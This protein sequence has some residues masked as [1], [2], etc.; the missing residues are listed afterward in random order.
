MRD[1]EARPP[2]PAMAAWAPA[3]MPKGGEGSRRGSAAGEGEAG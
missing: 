2:E 1:R 3:H